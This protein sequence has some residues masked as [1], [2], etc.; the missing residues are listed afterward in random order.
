MEI[1][2]IFIYANWNGRVTNLPT[3]TLNTEGD[4]LRKLLVPV[5][6]VLEMREVEEFCCIR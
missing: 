2:F 3:L 5:V 1:I 4:A 6:A